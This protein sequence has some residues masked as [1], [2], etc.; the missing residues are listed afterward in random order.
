MKETL[1]NEERE[2]LMRQHCKDHNV[3]FESDWDYIMRMEELERPKF[4]RNTTYSSETS[5]YFITLTSGKI[6]SP[7]P[8][9]ESIVRIL[10]QKR[11]K[12]SDGFG[13]IELTKA[14]K[15]HAHIYVESTKYISKSDISRI[16][17]EGFID[18]R[19]VK[20]DNG[21]RDYTEKDK[22]NEVLLNYLLEYKCERVYNHVK[23]T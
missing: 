10:K 21:I 19:N 6:I 1:S 8:F 17:K 22:D 2:E 16:W 20:K 14:G 12:I 3:P 15:P 9:A 11:L 7:I 5:K 18:V 13:C 4:K 23:P